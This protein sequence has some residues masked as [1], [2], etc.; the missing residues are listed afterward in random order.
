MQSNSFALNKHICKSI[1]KYENSQANKLRRTRDAGVRAIAYQHQKSALN[2]IS[3][4]YVG[5]LQSVCAVT[6]FFR[7]QNN[8]FPLRS[9]FTFTVQWTM[10]I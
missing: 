10:Y 3:N 1:E 8:I 5:E 4:Y 7:I 2:S 9:Y 6:L